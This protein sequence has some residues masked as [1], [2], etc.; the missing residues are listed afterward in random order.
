MKKLLISSILEYVIRYHPNTEIVSYHTSGHNESDIDNISQ[1]Y[2]YVEFGKRCKQVSNMLLNLLNKEQKKKNS[3]FVIGTLCCNSFQHL[4]LC[5][6][7]TSIGYIFHPINPKLDTEC[8]YYICKHAN[9]TIIFYDRCFEHIV[10][11]LKKRC[12][13]VVNWICMEESYETMIDLFLD[14]IV[15][16]YIE[17]NDHAVLCYTS[18]TT[19]KP[20]GVIYSHRDILLSSMMGISPDGV[21]ISAIDNVLPLQGFYYCNSWNFIFMMPLVGCKIVFIDDYSI[22]NLYIDL[23]TDI[24]QKEEVT[25]SAGLTSYWIYFLQHMK[26][27]HSLSRFRNLFLSKILIAGASLNQLFINHF[28][29]YTIDV[30]NCYGM[31]EN[32]YC[33]FYSNL[34]NKQD[35]I[36]DPFIGRF[37]PVFGIDMKIDEEDVENVNGEL[38]IQGLWTIRDYFKPKSDTLTNDWFSTD[39][40]CIIN[41]EGYLNVVEKKRDILKISGQWVS[42]SLLESIAMSHPDV[43]QSSCVSIGDSILGNIC[44]IVI[45]ARTKI[46]ETDILKLY[47]DRH[48]FPG[49]VI[50]IEE[51]PIS[52][53]DQVDKEILKQ[54][55]YNM[56]SDFIHING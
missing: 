49:Y 12:R 28:K 55:I 15:F 6:G 54:M 5:Y 29:E 22:N 23:F 26:E 14:D 4:E 42:S 36:Y 18:G 53:H 2:T 38:Y 21:G 50:F 10:N 27:N 9:D 56:M 24:L 48:Y 3:S 1:R 30:I 34:K 35:E 45:K 31:M 40:I 19:S 44:V 47:N 37:R 41:K 43:L 11:K 33:G 13:N 25:L 52:S 32:M 7:I 46:V 8:L 16:P 20:K 51:F 39:D 17:E